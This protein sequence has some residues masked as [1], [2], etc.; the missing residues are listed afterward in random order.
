MQARSYS[1]VAG[2]PRSYVSNAIF[3]SY[4]RDDSEGEAGR[5]FDDLVRAFG[6]E[7]VFMDVSG[8]K[9]GADFRT[10]IEDNVA[11][12]GVLLAVVGPAWVSITDAAGKRRLDDPNDFVALEI[13]SALKREVPVIPVL[14]HEARMPAPDKLPESL[15]AFSYRNSVELSHA[16]WNSDVQLLIN[17]LGAYV[18]PTAAA[19]TT[20]PVHATVAVQLPAPRT[21]MAKSEHVGSGSKLPLILGLAVV[22]LLAVAGLYYFLRVPTPA[23]ATTMVGNWQDPKTLSGNTLSRLEITGSGNTLSLH[24]FAYAC[25]PTPCD[26]GTQPASFDGKTAVATFAPAYPQGAPGATR[27]AVVTVHLVGSDLDVSVHNT[28]NDPSGPREN[29]VH[30]LF[31]PAP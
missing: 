27:I 20:Q 29:T 22:V 4:R 7:N 31:N 12:C 21:P 17:A 24:G 18:T 3:I 2:N 11:H 14:V 25:Q 23:P 28:F 13:A 26:W 1:D 30:R 15:N 5:L 19:V 10:A 16:R 8:I 6:T 9:P